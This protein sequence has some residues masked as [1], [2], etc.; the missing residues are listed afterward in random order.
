M[1][2]IWVRSKKETINQLINEKKLG[3]CILTC[4]RAGKIAMIVLKLR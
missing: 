2:V 4:K 1:P 3:A